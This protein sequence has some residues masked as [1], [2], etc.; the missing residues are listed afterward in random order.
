MYGTKKKT[1]KV[2]VG[3]TEYMKTSKPKFL[4]NKVLGVIQ[5]NLSI[6]YNIKNKT[7]FCG[8]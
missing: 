3:I 2:T 5:L 8:I 6:L 4:D 1:K 7:F